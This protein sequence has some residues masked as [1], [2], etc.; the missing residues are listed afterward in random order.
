MKREMPQG[1]ISTWTTMDLFS[2]LENKGDKEKTLRFLD[3]GIW[4]GPSYLKYKRMQELN[5]I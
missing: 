5:K 4:D 1:K 3:L 2:Y